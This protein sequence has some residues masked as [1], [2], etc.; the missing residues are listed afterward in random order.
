MHIIRETY[1][2]HSLQMP[3]PFVIQALHLAA[4]A[5]HQEVSG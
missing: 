1:F 4:A 3:H 5:V 2:T